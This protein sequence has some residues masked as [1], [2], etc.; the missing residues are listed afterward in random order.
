MNSLDKFNHLTIAMCLTC[1][2]ISLNK[3]TSSPLLSVMTSGRDSDDEMSSDFHLG[4]DSTYGNLKMHNKVSFLS[5][6]NLFKASSSPAT[7]TANSPE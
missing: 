2:N 4:D 1:T 6:G 7:T 3:D 5:V